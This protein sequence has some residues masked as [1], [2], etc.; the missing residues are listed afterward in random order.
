[1]KQEQGFLNTITE[2]HISSVSPPELGSNDR[3]MNC[4]RQNWNNLL[5][6]CNL[7]ESLLRK[8]MLWKVPLKVQRLTLI[9][10]IDSE[11]THTSMYFFKSLYKNSKTK[12]NLVSHWITSS[13]FTTFGCCNWFNKEISLIAV[14]GTPSVSLK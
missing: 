8:F 9:N 11:P 14:A 3:A 6:D 13:N 4:R 12:N 5:L 2:I 1:M 10:E 7:L